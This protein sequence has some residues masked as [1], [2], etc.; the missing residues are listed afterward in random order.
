MNTKRIYGEATMLSGLMRSYIVPPVS[1][2]EHDKRLLRRLHGYLLPVRSGC[3][4]V[5]IRPIQ[6]SRNR[7]HDMVET[8]G[9]VQN[10]DGSFPFANNQFAL[11]HNTRLHPGHPR[12]GK[13]KN[14]QPASRPVPSAR[15]RLP[16]L[17]TEDRPRERHS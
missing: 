15:R 12:G 16:P 13:K 7:R 17:C 10:E 5:L 1:Q 3:R 14:P 6:R 2:A 11:D 9:R 8:G 4:A